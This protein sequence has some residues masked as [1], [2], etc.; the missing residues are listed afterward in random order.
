MLNEEGRGKKEGARVEDRTEAPEAEGKALDVVVLENAGE[1]GKVNDETKEDASID[2]E[3][4]A[5]EKL[6]GVLYKA[7]GKLEEI[8][9]EYKGGEGKEGAGVLITEVTIEVEDVVETEIGI[10]V[11]LEVYVEV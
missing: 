9:D 1:V 7:E 3:T 4:G 10:E 2:A 11:E 8:C 5:S 6:A